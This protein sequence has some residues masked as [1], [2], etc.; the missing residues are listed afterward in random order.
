MV[1]AEVF[2]LQ[3]M[4]LP[5]VRKI[6]NV[7]SFLAYYKKPGDLA[8][9]GNNKNVTTTSTDDSLQNN[10]HIIVRKQLSQSGSNIKLK[11]KAS[12]RSN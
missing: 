1:R 10:M 5:E 3:T 9:S 11:V 6:V 7:L 2:Y 12:I 8:R 4:E